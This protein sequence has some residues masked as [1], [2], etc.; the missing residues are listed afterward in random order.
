MNDVDKSWI[1]WIILGLLIG[2]LIGKLLAIIISLFLDA[3]IYAL[4]IAA[5]EPISMIIALLVVLACYQK[6]KEKTIE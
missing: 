6:E 1:K 2:F 5:C 3:Q 4:I